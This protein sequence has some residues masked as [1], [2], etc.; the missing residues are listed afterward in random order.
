MKINENE[1][2]KNKITTFVD[3][4]PG[5]EQTFQKSN[6]MIKGKSSIKV[7]KHNHNLGNMLY[8]EMLLRMTE[9]F[10]LTNNKVIL[11]LKEMKDILGLGNTDY[12]RV[13]KQ[14][15]EELQEGKFELDHYTDRDGRY[16]EYIV[17]SLINSFKKEILPN[18]EIVYHI[19]VSEDMIEFLKEN[20]GGNYTLLN[21]KYTSI[22]SGI[23]QI[24]L[25]EHCKQYV[26][27]QKGRVP[28]LNLE[29]I[30]NILQSD[31]KYLSKAKEQIKKS[32]LGI[33]SKTD[34][35]V[36]FIKSED[37]KNIELLVQENENAVKDKQQT[38]KRKEMLNKSKGNGVFVSEE[39]IEKEKTI[40]DNLMNEN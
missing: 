2:S 21:C 40:I 1:L 13:I 22:L 12:N 39:D 23:K 5:M 20:S 6:R 29:D 3:I 31:Y 35:K 34:I 9:D 8:R 38:K 19:S 30:N 10:V 18:K 4:V 36:S 26:T 17:M 37:K 28:K 25:Y 33:N 14:S 32:I 15:L 11:S 27:F 7:S 16:F 24:K